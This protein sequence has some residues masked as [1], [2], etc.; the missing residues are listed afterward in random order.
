MPFS[1]IQ[2][3]LKKLGNGL[4]EPRQTG[5]DDAVTDGPAAANASNS[6]ET[7]D[8]SNQWTAEG[9]RVAQVM[10]DFFWDESYS[11]FR[12]SQAS[13]ETVG[14]WSGYVV[15][16][17]TIGV[18]ALLEAEAASP[19][20]FT[21]K[22]EKALDGIGKF[23]S[24]EFN[25]YCAW[26]WTAGNRDIYYDDNAQVVSAFLRA[27]QM[28]GLGNETY[29]EQAQK[30]A[31][32][33]FTGWE[34]D[35]GGGMKWHLDQTIRNACTGSLTAVAVL[36]LA[37]VLKNEGKGNGTDGYKT[38]DELVAFGE[39]CV[40][41]VIDNLQL[42]SGL[43]EDGENG[44]PTYTYNTGHTL[45]ALTLLNSLKPSSDLAAKAKTLATA[46]ID[47]NLTL[48]DT[49]VPE[50]D[51]RYWWDNTFFLHLLVEG[52]VS[53]VQVFG[54]DEPELATNVK[55]E[56]TRNMEYLHTYIVDNDDGMYWRGLELYTISMGH[57]A[58]YKELTGD[59]T[60]NASLNAEERWMDATSLTLPVAQRGMCKTL[61]GN[62]GAARSF[63][64][65]GTLV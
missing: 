22:I 60:R 39:A 9:V 10:W 37:Q 30:V 32:F 4:P 35:N 20:T 44:G 7:R 6:V 18:Q 14:N 51:L 50:E 8:L 2:H 27:Y 34:S 48:F 42:D 16:P 49:S 5:D 63:L 56:I 24:S 19:G 17:Y 65:A 29:L 40:T 23:F 57:L 12:T 36:Q 54:A 53:Y 15:W 33:L 43:I 47:R 25:A 59:T 21:D 52:L 41:W 55:A 38:V 28:P 46:A 1:R 31:G 11:H 3:F 61:L 62:G 26:I 13:S 64:I 45:H 58:V